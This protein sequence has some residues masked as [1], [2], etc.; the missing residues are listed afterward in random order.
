M[1]F[2]KMKRF[3]AADAKKYVKPFKEWMEQNSEYVRAGEEGDEWDFMFVMKAQKWESLMQEVYHIYP[4]MYVPPE[5]QRLAGIQR[6]RVFMLSAKYLEYV[7]VDYPQNTL[8][9][10]YWRENG[11]RRIGV[12]TM[13][14]VNVRMPKLSHLITLTPEDFF[15]VI[16]LIYHSQL[17]PGVKDRFRL[18]FAAAGLDLETLEENDGAF[19]KL[20]NTF[21]RRLQVN[22]VIN[23]DIAM[24]Q[25]MK[26]ADLETIVNLEPTLENQMYAIQYITASS[27]NDVTFFPTDAAIELELDWDQSSDER[28][29][30]RPMN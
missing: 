26:K 29:V 23:P 2:A 16:K 10:L 3:T 9:A 14:G 11:E 1:A 28:Y 24:K 13:M 22:Y 20:V 18:D 5:V 21:F 27:Q 7:Y 15:A 4:N 30:V 12:P 17:A 6:A 8:V 19:T 25:W